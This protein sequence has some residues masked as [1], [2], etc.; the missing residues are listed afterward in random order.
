MRIFKKRKTETESVKICEGITMSETFWNREEKRIQTLMLKGLLIYLTTMGG[1]GSYLSAVGVSCRWTAVNLTLLAA[2]FVCALC[3][4]RRLFENIGYMILFAFAVLFGYRHR[5]EINQGFYVVINRTLEHMAEYFNLKSLKTYDQQV[6]DPHQ[7]VTIAAVFIGVILCVIFNVLITRHMQY[8]AVFAL[9]VTVLLIPLY[10]DLQTGPGYL[11]MLLTGVTVLFILRGGRSYHV[12]ENNRIYERVK[13]SKKILKVKTIYNFIAYLQIFFAAAVTVILTVLVVYTI[14]P[15]EELADKSRKNLWKKGTQEEMEI[16]ISS[17]LE[18]FFNQY[19]NTGGMNHGRLGGVSSITLDYETDLEVTFTPYTD[20][21]IYLKSFDGVSYRPYEN[22]WVSQKEGMAYDKWLHNEAWKLQEAY[23]SGQEYAA[24]GKMRIADQVEGRTEVFMPYYTVQTIYDAYDYNTGTA[25]YYPRLPENQTEIWPSVPE[26]GTSDNP[27]S[28]LG[29]E[30]SIQTEISGCLELPIENY[31][32][33]SNLCESWNIRGT[34]QE[35]T[36]KIASYFQK[37]VPYTYTP[38]KTPED[39]DFINYFLTERKKGL[40]THFASA[41]VLM[42]RYRGI[43]ARYVEGYVIDYSEVLEGSLTEETYE[44]YYEGYSKLGKTGVV[45]VEVTDADAHAW[46][47]IFTPEKGWHP[48]EVTP[49][50][51]EAAGE[52]NFWRN[53]LRMFESGE[54]DGEPAGDTEGKE[55]QTETG[56]QILRGAGKTV[57][58][59][60]TVLLCL[61]LLYPLGR[62]LNYRARYQ[63]ADR[64]DRVILAYQRYLNHKKRKE[65][66]LKNQLNYEEQIQYL[67]E[68]GYLRFSSGE[69]REN[70][71]HILN[72]AGFSDREIS[73]EEYEKI[74]KILKK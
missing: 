41:A 42:F 8:A 50:A 63:R 62:Y 7:A 44:N 30:D 69:E 46:V 59:F 40:C 23:M 12:T 35:I 56:E 27:L 10:M 34:P 58:A 53:F 15:Q 18:G 22:R 19:S 60:L 13:R 20:E 55:P 21:R 38:G 31:S 6:A 65:K 51:N 52:G 57:T 17:G 3:F 49:S 39:E 47:E 25:E 68:K 26:E 48:V 74:L 37:N 67:E 29:G 16:L 24:R 66:A 70:I 61:G 9:T 14:I 33:I 45:K 36:E 54:K 72:Q 64:N 5:I 1:I 4:Y 73:E 2:S 28:S 32:V 43:P 11:M 71:L